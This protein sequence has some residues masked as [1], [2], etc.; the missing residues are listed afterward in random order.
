[1]ILSTVPNT[2]NKPSLLKTS[3]STSLMA[4]NETVDKQC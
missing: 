4:S 3:P 1:M 2:K